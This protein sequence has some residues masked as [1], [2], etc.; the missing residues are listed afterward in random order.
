MELRCSRRI[1]P[2]LVFGV[3]V[4]AVYG[5]GIHLAIDAANQVVSQ[6]YLLVVALAIT[7]TIGVPCFAFSWSLR[8]RHRLA[9]RRTERGFAAK[10][11]MKPGHRN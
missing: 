10:T 9:V 8:Y 5:Y 11:G 6:N 4:V 7:G 2:F 3:A 1:V